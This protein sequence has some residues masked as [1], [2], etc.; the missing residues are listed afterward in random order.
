MALSDVKRLKRCFAEGALVSP[1][2]AGPKLP[3]LS[4][5]LHALAGAGGAAPGAEARALGALVGP[6]R[7]YALVLLDGLGTEMLARA[8]AGGFLRG[9]VGGTLRTVFPST[10]AAALTALATGEHP[11]RHAVPGWWLWL[12]PPGLSAEVLPFVERF[13]R[14]PL[15]EHGVTPEQV[16]TVPS[17]V[18]RLGHQP[19]AIMPADIAGSAYSRYCA[20]GTATGGYRSPAEAL[21]LAAARVLA[22]EAPSFTYVYLP[23]VDALSHDHGVDSK[24]VAK[25]LAELDR[26]LG[27]FAARLAGRARIVVT[28]DHGLVNVPPERSFFLDEGDALL[29]HL[30]WVPNGEATALFLHVK[31]G[32][33]AAFRRDFRARYGECFALLAAAEA[34]RLGLF[35]PEPLS[36]LSRARVGDFIAFGW[37]PAALYYRPFDNA[38]GREPVERPRSGKVTVHRGAHGG[39]SPAE[40]LVPLILA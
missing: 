28:G 17:T 19:L 18:A 22:A 29:D 8:P 13:G 34:E 32:R 24:P 33:E 30:R 31:P 21:K 35:G 11:A 7:H 15:A 9:R 5:A 25:M 6:A 39:L 10:T 4:R 12:E 36:P 38:Q 16:F 2:G 14:R 20:G 26:L 27:D 23:Q 40:M 1:A 3:D 37:Q